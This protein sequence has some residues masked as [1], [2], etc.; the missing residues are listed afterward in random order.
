MSREEQQRA[1]FLILLFTFEVD[2]A[3]RV[4]MTVDAKQPS[5]FSCDSLILKASVRLPYFQK[6]MAIVEKSANFFG[7]VFFGF[8]WMMTPTPRP[9]ENWIFFLL[10]NTEGREFADLDVE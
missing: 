1:C 9:E 8:C 5:W 10:L 7:S 6:N 4:E 3:S 2:F